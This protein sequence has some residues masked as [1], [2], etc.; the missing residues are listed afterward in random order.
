MV[1]CNANCYNS[2]ETLSRSYLVR[3]VLLSIAAVLMLSPA[4]ARSLSAQQPTAA[5]T[6]ERV[7]A[8]YA[9][10]NASRDVALPRT[11]TVSDSAGLIVAHASINGEPRQIP[12]TVMALE[13]DLVLQ[14]QTTQGV[15]TL[16]LDRQ[17]EGGATRMS[18]GRWMLG[19]AEG[20]LRARAKR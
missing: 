9:I 3:P 8:T 14:G 13:S 18:S 10:R 11:V 6:T 20:T 15:L 5:I 2:L 12:L 7:V 4:A 19:A 1:T 17:N 16:V